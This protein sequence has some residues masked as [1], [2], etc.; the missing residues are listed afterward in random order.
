M[1]R[2]QKKDK[3]RKGAILI[4]WIVVFAIAG[5]ITWADNPFRY[6]KLN[7]PKIPATDLRK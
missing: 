5:L 7:Q 1:S 6:L 4:S 2:T 3:Q